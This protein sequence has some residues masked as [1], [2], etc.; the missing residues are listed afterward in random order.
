MLR[1]GDILKPIAT[2]FDLDL[3][4]PDQH[5]MR[6]AGPVEGDWLCGECEDQ[7]ADSEGHESGEEGAAAGA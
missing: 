1:L 7:P 4:R 2:G 3:S 6:F 5:K